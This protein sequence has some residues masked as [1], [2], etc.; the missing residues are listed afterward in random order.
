[1]VRYAELRCLW[2]LGVLLTAAACLMAV[3]PGIHL[4]KFGVAPSES[5]VWDAGH[6]LGFGVIAG[7]WYVILALPRLSDQNQHKSAIVPVVLGFSIVLGI[8]TET[9]QIFVLDHTPSIGDFWI[10]ML[11]ASMGLTFISGLSHSAKEDHLKAQE[12]L[13]WIFLI[14]LAGASIWYL[15]NN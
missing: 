8:G 3:V 1:M 2:T 10:D 14:G 7:I 6:I 9:G 11:G 13:F 12:A 4:P 15:P 5:Y